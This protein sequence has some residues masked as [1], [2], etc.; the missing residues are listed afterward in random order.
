MDFAKN[1]MLSLSFLCA[2]QVVT[3]H[4]TAIEKYISGLDFWKSL[5]IMKKSSQSMTSHEK[6][7]DADFISCRNN[8]VGFGA[9]C[10]ILPEGG[11]VVGT[12]T[13]P[14]YNITCIA[15]R[16]YY[17]AAAVVSILCI[18]CAKRYFSKS[19][20]ETYEKSKN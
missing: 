13:V 1:I 14:Y 11:P 16:S 19:K 7:G 6:I 8:I 18:A 2:S 10:E 5:E 20:K 9:N 15:P 4:E 12:V 3:A 17:V